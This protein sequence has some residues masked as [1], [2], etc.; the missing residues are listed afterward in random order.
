MPLDMIIALPKMLAGK[1][2]LNM[3]TK[4]PSLT[5]I[6]PGSGKDATEIYKT[7]SIEMNLNTFASTNPNDLYTKYGTL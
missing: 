3:T 2:I 5:P 4:L 6:D 1:N 7:A